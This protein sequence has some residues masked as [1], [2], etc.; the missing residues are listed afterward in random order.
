[1]TNEGRG[2][3]TVHGLDVLTPED[4]RITLF[5]AGDTFQNCT[6]AN[7][8]AEVF[9]FNAPENRDFGAKDTV[10]VYWGK[11]NS[12]S[13]PARCRRASTIRKRYPEPG[14]SGARPPCPPPDA[15]ALGSQPTAQL[16]LQ[17][18]ARRCVA[19]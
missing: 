8:S 13:I 2:K 5:G 19:V 7:G 18:E 15:R 6:L 1:M 17:C 12:A 16:A 10:V 4:E 11:T 9:D 14:S 3:G